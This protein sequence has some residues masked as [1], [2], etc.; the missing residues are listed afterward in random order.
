M[1]NSPQAWL[2]REIGPSF[3]RRSTNEIFPWSTCAMMA[4]LRIFS[5]T[6]MTR[7]VKPEGVESTE[8]VGGRQE[9]APALLPDLLV[10]RPG[11]VLALPVTRDPD[12]VRAH[13]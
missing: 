6:C 10:P 8:F 9:S 7:K 4:T 2:S 13:L 5:T 1:M 3:R 12:A 11:V